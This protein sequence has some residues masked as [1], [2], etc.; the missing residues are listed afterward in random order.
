MK[1]EEWAGDWRIVFIHRW[2]FSLTE[3]KFPQPALLCDAR[4]TAAN[5]KCQ[6]GASPV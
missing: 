3:P 6:E 4:T 2:W 1:R 5:G